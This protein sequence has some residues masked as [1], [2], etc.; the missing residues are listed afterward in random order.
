MQGNETPLESD[1][2]PTQIHWFLIAIIA[3][4]TVLGD[5]YLPGWRVPVIATTMPAAFA[6]ICGRKL[7]SRVGYWILIAL[8]T[9][10]FWIINSQLR[11]WMNGI[12]TILSLAVVGGV[13]MLAIMAV[14]VRVFPEAKKR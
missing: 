1:K 13:E 3:L 2:T 6:I 9:M 4:E 8:L 7:Y 11:N 12:E 5:R 10:L 14:T